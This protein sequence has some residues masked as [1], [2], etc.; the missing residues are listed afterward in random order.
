M[1]A[2]YPRCCLL[3]N[4]ARLLDRGVAASQRSSGARW[5]GVGHAGLLRF[6]GRRRSPRQSDGERGGRAPCA[7][8]RDLSPQG[9]AQLAGD[10]GPEPGPGLLSLPAGP[11]EAPEDPLLVLGRDADAV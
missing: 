4:V 9:L 11:L 7:G 8:D 2:N 5:L 10:P 1:D 3:V 6:D